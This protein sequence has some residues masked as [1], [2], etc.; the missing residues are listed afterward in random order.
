MKELERPTHEAQSCIHA[1][2]TQ[3]IC[4]TNGNFS[5]TSLHM[6][7]LQLRREGGNSY[8]TSILHHLKRYSDLNLGSNLQPQRYSD[9]D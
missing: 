7:N 1:I 6:F 8:F 5:K 2:Q 4:S 3:S 9:L